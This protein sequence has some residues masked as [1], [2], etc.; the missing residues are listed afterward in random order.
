M[1]ESNPSI[2]SLPEEQTRE[3]SRK[4]FMNK[5]TYFLSSFPV[6]VRAGYGPDPLYQGRSGPHI[7]NILLTKPCVCQQFQPRW[8][9]LVFVNN[10]NHVD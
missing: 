6:L 8:L 5:L 10:F 2:R 3:K 1:R 9:S 7:L 4:Y